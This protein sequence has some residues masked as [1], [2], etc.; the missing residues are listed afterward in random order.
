MVRNKIKL[1]KSNVNVDLFHMNNLEE[2][3][4]VEMKRVLVFTSVS[5]EL[6]QVRQYEIP[7]ISEPQVMKSHIEM[8]EIGPRFDL[9]FRRNQV[10]AP[11]LFKIACRKP[12]IT[13][14]LKKKVIITNLF[15]RYIYRLRKTCIQQRLETRKPEYFFSNKI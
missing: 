10:A 4:I 9:K 2:A 11:D 6:I 3:N 13:N 14:M 8:K 7:K 12:K 15:I 1:I 5:E